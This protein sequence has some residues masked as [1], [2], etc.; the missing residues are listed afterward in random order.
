MNAIIAG[1]ISKNRN[2]PFPDGSVDEVDFAVL[3]QGGG[4]EGGLGFPMIQFVWFENGIRR[5]PFKVCG[6]G[7]FDL[8]RRNFWELGDRADF[9]RGCFF[10]RD[11]LQRFFNN[12]TR[13]L[14]NFNDRLRF[15]SSRNTG[16]LAETVVLLRTA[17]EINNFGKSRFPPSNER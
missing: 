14:L 15:L 13:W 2:I 10:R 4:V 6:N 12:P 7:L 1:R 5:C 17:E 11:W 8:L 9:S 16:S 3:V